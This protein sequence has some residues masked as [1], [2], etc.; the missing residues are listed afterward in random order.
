MGGTDV[1]GD[2][3]RPTVATGM[4]DTDDLHSIALFLFQGKKLPPWGGAKFAN[5]FPPK[6]H[7]E[8]RFG[9]ASWKRE[10]W[11][12]RLFIEFLKK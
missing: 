4:K 12:Q 6:L 3:D 8:M 10:I 9:N 5:S 7:L 2:R 1:G 11:F